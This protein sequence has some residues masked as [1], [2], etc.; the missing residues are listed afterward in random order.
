KDNDVD[1]YRSAA[2]TD[3]L[4]GLLNRRAFLENALSLCAR[5]GERGQPVTMLMLDLDHFK[6]INDRFGHAIGDEVLRVFANAARSNMRG[7]DLVGR[8]GG[9]E[10][11]VIVAEPMQFAARIGERLRVSFETAGIQIGEHAIGATLSIGAATSHEP[12]TDIAALIARAD[13]ALYRAK[14]D[15]RNRL[16]AA[17][18]EPPS[19]DARPLAAARNGQAAKPARLSQGKGP[20]R[21]AKSVGL[22]AIGENATSRLPS[23]R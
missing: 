15:G 17:D 21:R 13:A 10:F 4:T 3:P 18:A 22:A 23:A 2:F 19:Q 9:E 8:L 20:A 6:S 1:L 5:Q 14:H 7:S 12:V 11:A 16:Y